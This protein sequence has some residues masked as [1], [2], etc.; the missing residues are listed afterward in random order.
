MENHTKIID[1][2]LYM[3]H[4]FTFR[5]I[6]YIGS[7]MCYFIL[8]FLNQ[9][10]RNASLKFMNFGINAQLK[11]ELIYIRWSKFFKTHIYV[12]HNRQ[13]VYFLPTIFFFRNRSRIYLKMEFIDSL[14]LA[15]IYDWYLA[16]D[17]CCFHH[18]CWHTPTLWSTLVPFSPLAHTASGI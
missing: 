1:L 11:S 17:I 4:F 14:V 6:I 3:D 18:V 10:L 13:L 12:S 8:L 9:Y 5:L 2:V 15:S 16:V 7:F